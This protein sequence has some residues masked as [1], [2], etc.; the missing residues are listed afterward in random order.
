LIKLSTKSHQ[1]RGGKIN[2]GKQK[3]LMGP[4]QRQGAAGGFGDLNKVNKSGYSIGEFMTMGNRKCPK[5]KGPIHRDEKSNYR[6]RE[7]SFCEREISWG[8]GEGKRAFPNQ[9]IRSVI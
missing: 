1:K 4:G 8:P 2:Y 6:V 5:E 3:K 7:G 9:E